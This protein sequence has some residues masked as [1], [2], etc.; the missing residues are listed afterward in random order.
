MIS[1]AKI[2]GIGVLFYMFLSGIFTV[3]FVDN[4]EIA[5]TFNGLRD[6]YWTEFADKAMADADGLVRGDF[7]KTD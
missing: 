7:F 3:D 4:G 5:L 2:A 6:G 1:F